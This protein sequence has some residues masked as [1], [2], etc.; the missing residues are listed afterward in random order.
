MDVGGEDVWRGGD[1]EGVYG[2]V[3]EDE[4][5]FLGAEDGEDEEDDDEEDEVEDEKADAKAF[6]EPFAPAAVVVTHFN[7]HG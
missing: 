5:W 4:F 2:G 3:L 1:V 7:R 6:E